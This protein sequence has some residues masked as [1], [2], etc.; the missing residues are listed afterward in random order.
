MHHIY[1]SKK[2][3]AIFEKSIYLSNKDVRMV[4]R[5]CHGVM[6]KQMRGCW[7]FGGKENE[8]HRFFGFPILFCTSRFTINVLS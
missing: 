2:C 3:L 8:A 5:P 4:K 6:H 7:I 1:L